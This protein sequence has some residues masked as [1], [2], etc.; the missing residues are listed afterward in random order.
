MDKLQAIAALCKCSFYLEFNPHREVCETVAQYFSKFGSFGSASLAS[1]IGPDVLGVM[2]AKETIVHLRVY[3]RTHVC[4]YHFSLDAV[5]D[6][7]LVVLNN[8][9]QQDKKDNTIKQ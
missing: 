8:D 7:A 3:P 1:E 9:V 6:K 4:F 2:L 5:L